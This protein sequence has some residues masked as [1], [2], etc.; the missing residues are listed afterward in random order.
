[1]EKNQQIIIPERDELDKEAIEVLIEN[2]GITKAAFFI[3]ENLSKKIDYLNIK[4]NI[5][6]NKSIDDIVQ[7]IKYYKK[8]TIEYSG[9]I[10][11]KEIKYKTSKKK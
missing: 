1:M 8:N 4:K 6:Q 11:E 7:D 5:V 9:F 2:L 10:K 3:R